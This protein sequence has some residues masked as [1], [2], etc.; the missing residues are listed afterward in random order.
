[1]IGGV[2]ASVLTGLLI[3]PLGWRWL[4]LLYALPGLAWAVCFAVWFRN[5]PRDHPAVNT[6]ELAI[7]SPESTVPVLQDTST[8]ART[9]V[10][11][12]KEMGITSQF[13]ALTGT[14]PANISPPPAEKH[15]LN[16]AREIEG[17][18]QAKRV[19]DPTISWLTIFLSSALW[20]ICIQQFCRA[21]AL[22]FF[23]QWLPTYLQEARGLIAGV[24]KPVDESALVGRRDRR[25][26]RRHPLGCGAGAH[27]QPAAARQ[28][29]AIGSI[30]VGL[31][32]YGLAYLISDV[33]GAVLTAC[34]G[35]FIMTFSSPCAYALTWTWAA[36]I[37]A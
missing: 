23:D 25:S 13:E 9:E 4:F 21:G 15:G 3:G 10:N 8:S 29:V 12:A 18:D 14:E 19:V 27:G 36:E 17:Q 22:R 24:G 31:L 11:S 35:L 7:I 1:M 16:L 20:M 2:I 32:I 28:G 30:V 5:R 6:A 34:L 26:H 37:W 33:R